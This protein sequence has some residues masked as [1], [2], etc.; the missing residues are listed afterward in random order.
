M[1]ELVERVAG[2]RI[3]RAKRTSKKN[4]LSTNHPEIGAEWHPSKNDQLKPEDVTRA[5]NKKVWWLCP[6][7]HEYDMAIHNRTAKRRSGCPF[8]AGKRTS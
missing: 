6:K 4:N 3:V 2:A 5:S 1:P 7:G 8:C